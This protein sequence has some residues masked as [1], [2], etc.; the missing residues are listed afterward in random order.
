MGV[1]N[2]FLKK[3]KTKVTLY[4]NS[5]VFVARVSFAVSV[6]LALIIIFLGYLEGSL[7]YQTNGLVAL[8]DIVNSALLL[9]AVVYSEKTPDVI[10]NYGYGKYESL[11]IF[12]SSTL[13]IFVTVYT[14]IGVIGSLGN[15]KPIGNYQYLTLFSLIS[16]IIMFQMHKYLNNAYL[17]YKLEILRYDSELWKNDF[18]IEIGILFN[19][20]LC[21]ILDQFGFIELARI[22]DSL[23]A[24]ALVVIAMRI[25]IK[26]GKKSI[27]QLL[28]R[29]LPEQF[30]FDILSVIAENFKFLCE[31][32]TIY[33]RQSG[34][35]IFI[36]IDIVLPYD[37]T[38]EEAYTVQTKIEE[39]IK[40][41]YPNALPRVYYSPCKRDCIHI[42]TDS[43]PV[44]KW[45]YQTNSVD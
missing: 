35:D 28:D 40:N 42:K 12:I 33:T 37:F 2:L 16:I 23:G 3:T 44:K 30:H 10:Y 41:I 24:I 21:F 11:G 38:L 13:I 15:I 34:K 18:I 7:F 43:C 32:H 26:Y 27:D 25:P 1:T 17:H 14:I 19:L 45:I 8:T 39:K 20:A 5:S 36:E 4:R 31:F 22:F 6:L 29:K 9:Y